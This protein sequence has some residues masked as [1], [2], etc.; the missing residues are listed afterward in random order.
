METDAYQLSYRI[1]Q[2]VGVILLL[3]LLVF[4][5]LSL[6]KV[7]TAPQGK[8]AGWVVGL[9]ISTVLLSGIMLASIF[10]SS[11]SRIGNSVAEDSFKNIPASDGSFQLKVPSSW[12]LLPEIPVE[13]NLK[14]G[15]L[16]AEQ[17]C[18]VEMEPKALLE[19]TLEEVDTIVFENSADKLTKNITGGAPKKLVINGLPAIQ[20]KCDATV[21]GL[22]VTYVRATLESKTKFFYINTWTM[23]SRAPLNV[24]VLDQVIRSFTAKE[25]PPVPETEVEMVAAKD[26]EPR[27]IKI[28]AEQLGKTP[29]EVKPETTLKELGSDDLDQVEL[30]MAMEE[31]FDL[32]VPD[33]EAEK[34]LKV[35]DLIE[36]AKANAKVPANLPEV[37]ATLPKE[38]LLHPRFFGGKGTEFDAGSAFVGETEPGKLLLLTA[39]HLFSPAGGLEKDVL[40]SQMDKEYPKAEG[41]MDDGKEVGAAGSEVVLLPSA[42]G[43]DENSA[44]FDLAAYKLGTEPKAAALKFSKKNPK[45]GDVVY[46]DSRYI[47]WAAAEVVSVKKT[48]LVYRYYLPNLELRG[49]SGAPVVNADGEVVA[50]NLGGWKAKSTFGIGNGVEGMRSLLLKAK[51]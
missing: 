51:Q 5:I 2:I 3:G 38:A 31:E 21:K 47:G 20:R 25:G 32:S 48:K 23:A 27:L 43:M 34:F 8:K 37:P 28:L 12:K 30:V 50:M 10:K 14:A 26:V 46:M 41:I 44:A 29:A 40:W 16:V 49:T 17:Y 42:H 24:P 19:K 33:E 45:V 7:C 36:Y 4:F 15:N 18:V 9:V 39:Q 35:S 11:G 6:V 22:K 1:G 13:A